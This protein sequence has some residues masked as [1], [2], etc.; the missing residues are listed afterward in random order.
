MSKLLILFAMLAA[1]P[2][3][4][5]AQG[6]PPVPPPP[7]PSG[8]P[9]PRPDFQMMRQ[10]M[11]QQEAMHKQFRAKILGLLTPAHRNQLASVIG[12]L[13]IAASPDPRAAIKKIDAF[14]SSGE[15]QAILNAAQAFLTQQRALHQQMMAKFRV[16]NP[17]FPSPRPMPSRE[18]KLRHT[19]DAG[20]LL[21]M[22]AT[23]GG[24]GMGAHTFM[25]ERG[26][27][28]PHGGF[29]PPGGFMRRPRPSP[30]PT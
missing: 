2:A 26:R 13:A 6:V 19:P 25:L 12:Q 15:K 7:G 30:M 10:N 28:G 18:A 24:P 29:G 17:N 27:M 21:F 3:F 23:G 22:L 16:D 9:W 20:A 4:V 11:Q 5:L 8:A 1:I 14:L